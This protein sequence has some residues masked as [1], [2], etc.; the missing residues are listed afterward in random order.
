MKAKNLQM[1]EIRFFLDP[2]IDVPR[3]KVMGALE[4]MGFI[5]DIKSRINDENYQRGSKIDGYDVMEFLS[6]HFLRG[7]KYEPKQGPYES[8]GIAYNVSV[9]PKKWNIPVIGPIKV[10]KKTSF[11]LCRYESHICMVPTP[12]LEFWDDI[13]S[14]LALGSEEE[15]PSDME[16]KINAKVDSIAQKVRKDYEKIFDIKRYDRIPEDFEIAFRIHRTGKVEL[17]GHKRM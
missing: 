15:V 9:V 14:L 6:N 5:E 12:E 17:S 7:G 11:D 3:Y 1:P 4:D 10:G 13:G 16:R 2:K 8:V